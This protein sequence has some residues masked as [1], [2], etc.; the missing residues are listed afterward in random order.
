[1]TTVVLDS[2]FSLE[3]P[4]TKS[5]VLAAIAQ[6]QGLL[7]EPAPSWLRDFQGEPFRR[8]LAA[9]R[10]FGGVMLTM[11]VGTGKTY[12]SLA[13]G[14]AIARSAPI[15]VV[16][17]AV[18]VAQWRRVASSLRIPVE[19]ISHEAVSRG[20][21]P[22][23]AGPVIIDE[24][25]RF[26][27]PSTRR[28]RTIAPAL[29]GRP[30]IL[31]T[32][33][34]I[35]N[36]ID[37]LA[38]QLVLAVRAGHGGFG[39]LVVR[40]DGGKA[41]RRQ[42]G[43]DG[44]K[45]AGRQDGKEL[46]DRICTRIAAPAD[47]V[48][49]RVLVGLDRLRYASD[50]GVAAMI[51]IGM[52]RAL[53]SSPAAL[54][55]TLGRYRR[56][57]DHA[58]RASQAGHRPSRRAILEAIGADPEQLML[59]E[60]LPEAEP[61]APDLALGD[62]RRLGSLCRQLRRWSDRGDAKLGQLRTL[63]SD[64]RP[65]IVFATSVATVRYLRDRLG[66][67]GAAW[68]SGSGAGFGSS[69]ASRATVLAAFDPADPSWPTAM[70]RP[71][72]LLA[73][74][75]AAEGL[76]FQRVSRVIHYDL[77]WTAVRLAQRDGRA[78][79]LGSAHP[80]VE[81]VRFDLPETLERR[82]AIERAIERKAA[83]PARLGLGPDSAPGGPALA[84][85]TA[86]PTPGWVVLASDR[87]GAV[88]AV[89]AGS[90]GVLLEQHD[91]RAWHPA[92][93]AEILSRCAGSEVSSTTIEIGPLLESLTAAI[94][95]WLTRRDLGTSVPGRPGRRSAMRVVRSRSAELWRARRGRELEEV[96]RVERFLG[97][98]HSAGEARLA[99]A[100]GSGSSAAYAR[101]AELG[102]RE[103][104]AEAARIVAIVVFRPPSS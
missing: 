19:V 49:D 26:R 98:G 73:S 85:P 61:T 25:H 54:L 79:R 76:N 2:A 101:A 31:V 90:A 30:V 91:G 48:F 11:P 7:A 42:G 78:I 33:T 9:V 3:R 20:H 96:G 66:F 80:T 46:P 53:G 1:M 17:P 60:L 35:V 97:R 39:E 71:W 38:A 103:S 95:D 12:V 4:V 51:R 5:G 83:L 24:S 41:A 23:G 56:L 47:P 62:R 63:L 16:A 92:E 32:A 69:R 84:W 86:T 70:P 82:I 34:P 28:Y 75:V 8:G 44:G 15:T 59:W 74:D 93:P 67:S 22:G 43:K 18:L 13:I 40:T 72:L 10:R 14:Q 27:A 57:L 36:R 21:A 87:A 45:A 88:A 68:I 64:R 94:T 29:V 58:G 50:P 102:G 81:V 100:I 89:A 37:D 99:D 55:A 6:S 65:S 52:W 77:P 104:L